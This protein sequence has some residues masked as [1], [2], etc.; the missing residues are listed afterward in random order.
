MYCPQ[1]AAQNIEGAKFCRAC[2]ADIRLVS[3]ALQGS[4]PSGVEQARVE[5]GQE[6]DKRRKKQQ[7]PARIDRGVQEIFKGIGFLCV[8][9]VAM[10][11]FRGAFWWTI[12]FVIPAFKN[13]GDGIGQIVRARQEQRQLTMASSL[14]ENAS[15]RTMPLASAP[16][17]KELSSPDT[18][19]IVYHAP[20]SV[21]EMTTRHLDA[22][23]ERG[24]RN[25]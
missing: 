23:P 2:G 6:V 5:I 24:A 19:E 4:L 16:S 1:C 10:L 11:A 8:V 18:A 20:A 12:W 13:I 9:L 25:A 17:F 14:S 7:R 21:T 15:V 3:R 22:P